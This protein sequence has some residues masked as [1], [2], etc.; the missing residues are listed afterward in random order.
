MKVART[1]EQ[2]QKKGLNS[3]IIQG[4]KSCPTLYAYELEDVNKLDSI[5]AAL[6][7][8]SKLKI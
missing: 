6:L 2:K 8:F 7:S 3:R 1:T 5:K 4:K